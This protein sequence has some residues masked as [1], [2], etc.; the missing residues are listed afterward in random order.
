MRSHNNH[1][2]ETGGEIKRIYFK[3]A[4]IIIFA[5]LNFFMLVLIILYKIFDVKSLLIMLFEGAALLAG[6]IMYYFSVRQ[7]NEKG[8]QYLWIGGMKTFYWR[9]VRSVYT[10]PTFPTAN[11]TNIWFDNSK[12]WHFL[13]LAS[14][15][16][17]DYYQ[18]LEEIVGYI[19]I[20]NPNLEIEAGVFRQIGHF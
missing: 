20:E 15:A 10:V 8:Y 6:T 7:Y 5:L 12:K 4:P 2:F 17:K 14:F 9:D 16:T 1:H 19:K 13:R 3:G 11:G 18:V